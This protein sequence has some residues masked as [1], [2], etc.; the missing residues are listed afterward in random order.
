MKKQYQLQQKLASDIY[1]VPR[2][3]PELAGKIA[4]LKNCKNQ[5]EG[6]VL[7]YQIKWLLTG[8]AFF[9]APQKSDYLITSPVE[10]TY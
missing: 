3:R 10:N 7:Q 9:R 5:H 4:G 8:R 1:T 2:T 6:V